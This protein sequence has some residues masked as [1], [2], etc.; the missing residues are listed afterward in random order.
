VQAVRSATAPA[1][2]VA[3]AP[4][5]KRPEPPVLLEPPPRLPE[6]AP[7]LTPPPAAPLP[8]APL[9]AAPLPAA[10]LPAA[11]PKPSIAAKPAPKKATPASDPT[12]IAK[13]TEPVA[14]PPATASEPVRTP[15]ERASRLR[16]ERG[17]LEGARRALGSGSSAPALAA[18]AEHEAR[19]SDGALVEEREALRVQA[20]VR[21]GRGD[22]ARVALSRFKARFPSSLFTPA[23][24]ALLP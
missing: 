15:E 10:A 2:I 20:L 23:L 17:L 5:V 6:L 11:P 19:F 13:P 14:S 12:G 3:A 16:E 4:V 24:D 8:A 1:P 18:I 22:E 9:P 7:A 21:A